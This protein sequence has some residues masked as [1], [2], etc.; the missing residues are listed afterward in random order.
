MRLE[1][2]SHKA[3]VYACMNFHYAKSVPVNVTGFSVFNDENEWCGVILYGSG[4]NN[5][6]GIPFGLKS[7]QCVELVRMAL[8]GKHSETSKVL[9]ISLKLIKKQLPLCKLIVSYADK[10]Q[11]HKGIIYQATNF[12]YVG[13]SMLNSTDSSWIVNGK[14]YHGRIISDWVKAKGGLKGLSRKEFLK[15]NFDIN[16]TEYITAGKLKYIYPLYKSLIPLC[17]SLSKPY[18]KRQTNAS[19]VLPVAQQASSQQE[20]FDSTHS[21]YFY[22]YGI[23][24]QEN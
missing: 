13:T 14:R 23:R 18:P 11:N 17:K 16:A 1:K 2:A 3:I 24:P 8:N 20:G 5:N 21:L 22:N 7:G 9:S 12:Y 10:D 19:E 6:I 15:K 4:A